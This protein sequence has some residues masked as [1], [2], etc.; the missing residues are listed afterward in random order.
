MNTSKA[1]EEVVGKKAKRLKL[2]A[3]EP[4][5]QLIPNP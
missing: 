4:T 3:L 1:G 5:T 2:Y